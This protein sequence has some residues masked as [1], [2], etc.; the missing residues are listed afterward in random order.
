MRSGRRRLTAALAL[1]AFA[2]V[3]P[4]LAETLVTS[5]S[6]HRVLINSNYTG[7]SIAIF[8]AI[9]RDAQTIARASSFDVVV[10]VRG[11][12]QFI[13][14]REKERLGPLWL[15]QEQQKFPEAPSYLSVLSS[16]PVTEI[17]NDLL[18]ARQKVGLDAVVNAPGFTNDRGGRDDPF[19][20][21]LLR[22]KAREGLYHDLERGVTFLT[23]NLFR[24]AIPLPAIAPPGNYDV[25]VVLFADSVPLA[26]TNTSFELV[27]TGF[28]QRVGEVAHDWSLVYGLATAALAIVFGW[29][30][31][32]I[33]RRD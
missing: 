29:T 6:N 9:E 20:A 17:T 3:S 24:A 15:N 10:T 31:S 4:A 18:R 23:P 16:R 12:R 33:F 14:V 13:T 8:G 26:R 2:A 22:I 30:A 27:K 32:V 19:R 11:P 7:T 5:L 28:E 21:A 25:D 1:F